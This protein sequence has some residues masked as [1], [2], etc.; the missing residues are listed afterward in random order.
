HVKR[1]ASRQSKR[2]QFEFWRAMLIFYRKHYRAQTPL[3]LHS[4]VMAALL[5]KGGRGLWGEMRRNAATSL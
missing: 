5:V 3:W 1:A 4:L 2:A